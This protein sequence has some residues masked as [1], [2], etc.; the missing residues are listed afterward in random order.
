MVSHPDRILREAVKRMMPKTPLGRK[1][2][3]KLK[4]FA[5]TEHP[6]QAQ[7]PVDLKS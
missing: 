2:I 4:I 5:G 1:Q 3:S 6:H 7:Q